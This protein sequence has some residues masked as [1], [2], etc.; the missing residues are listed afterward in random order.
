MRAADVGLASASGSAENLALAEASPTDSHADSG[1][2][3]V[4][5][6]DDDLPRPGKV[7]DVPSLSTVLKQST[8]A[9]MAIAAKTATNIE[10]VDASDLPAVWRGLLMA[11][12]EQVGLKALVAGGRLDS[13]TEDQAVI[14]YQPQNDQFLKMLVRN[15]KKE[16]VSAVLSRVVGRPLGI[17]FEVDATT[18]AI[19]T[20]VATTTPAARPLP[21]ARPA[22]PAAQLE[23]PIVVNAST[24]PTPEQLQ[25]FEKDPLIAGL[26]SEFGATIVK[27]SEE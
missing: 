2:N 4:A 27:V 10:P 1:F 21:A 20:A 14:R 26:M 15:G 23:A 12:E 24:R 9:P 18:A 3:G 5:L 11:L 7:W 19:E 22:A 16:K 8:P 13:I 6:D 17:R 25:E